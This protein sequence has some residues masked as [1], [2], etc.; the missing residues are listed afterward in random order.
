[1]AAMGQRPPQHSWIIEAVADFETE[2]SWILHGSVRRS[3]FV[4]CRSSR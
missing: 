2:I 3:G 1:M 4:T